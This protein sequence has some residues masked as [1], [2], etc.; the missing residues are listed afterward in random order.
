QRTPP[1]PSRYSGGRR[2]P[3]FFARHAGSNTSRR[4]PIFNTR[5]MLG[6]VLLGQKKYADAEP[7]LQSG[8]DGMNER[9]AK[10]PPQG[11]DRL[12]EATFPGCKAEV[13]DGRLYLRDAGYQRLAVTA[14]AVTGKDAWP[15][16]LKVVARLG[17]TAGAAGTWYV[18]VSV[19][20]V[21]VVFHPDKRGGAFRA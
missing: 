9:A 21:K 18:G 14:R 15:D 20:R 5:S 10:I 16:S 19:G 17:G 3:A 6:G 11:K 12:T 1:R 2:R 7:L 13:K 4:I 8:Y